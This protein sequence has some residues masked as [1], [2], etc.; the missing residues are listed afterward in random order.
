MNFIDQV[1]VTAYLKTRDETAFRLLYNRHAQ[2]IW[3]MAMKLTEGNAHE[4]EEMVQDTWL[5]AI[6]GLP[7]FEWKASL[8]T[9]IIKILINRWREIKRKRKL[10]ALEEI[11]LPSSNHETGIND[12]RN[13]IASLPEGYQAVLLLHDLE[14]YKHEEIALMLD[15]AP[16]TSKSQLH[17]A[18]KAV[19]KLIQKDNY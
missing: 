9:W 6:A 16:G 12:T 17:Q 2:S 15:I 4:S 3:S 7:S 5:R 10:V 8:R 14:G 18:R 11:H 13:I 19:R 1:L